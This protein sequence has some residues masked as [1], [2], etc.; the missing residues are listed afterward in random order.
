ME[1]VLSTETPLTEHNVTRITYIDPYP[2]V[3]SGVLHQDDEGPII[4][5]TIEQFD[6]FIFVVGFFLI[7][8]SSIIGTIGNVYGLYIL[9]RDANSQKNNFLFYMFALLMENAVQCTNALIYDVP[10]INMMYDADPGNTLEKYVIQTTVYIGK[11]FCSQSVNPDVIGAPVFSSATL[12]LST[13]LAFQ[14]CPTCV[15]DC[16]YHL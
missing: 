10:W 12:L 5:L 16:F 7:P 13:N 11:V 1:D 8:I 6:E 4:P 15:I 3:Y 14:T 2:D 9:R